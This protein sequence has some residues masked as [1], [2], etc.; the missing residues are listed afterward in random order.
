MRE[1]VCA[2][3]GEPKPEI[4]FELLRSGRPRSVCRTC[5]SQQKRAA[6]ARAGRNVRHGAG[7][8]ARC[9]LRWCADGPL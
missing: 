8:G 6:D 3:C 9:Y 4:A 2:K 5:R 7:Y 1:I